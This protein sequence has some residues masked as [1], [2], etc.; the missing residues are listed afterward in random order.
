M[1][2]AHFHLLV[3]HIP[4]IGVV[5]GILILTAGFIF[6]INM[7]KRTALGVFIF[8]AM[9]AIPAFLSGEGAEEVIEKL[10]GV[11]E[12]YI[13]AHEEIA[14]IFI[15]IIATL[16][17]L[18]LVTFLSE[19]FKTKYSKLLYLLTAIMAIAT[20]VV[21][22][23]VGTTGGE[24]RHIEIRATQSPVNNNSIKPEEDKDD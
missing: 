22:K 23:Q 18:S 13:K 5:I 8:S 11:S 7:V 16:G 1:N 3:N 9:F 17:V 12:T 15:W 20:I 19:Y 6:K 21:A 14:E 10:P 24:I 4:I 2:E